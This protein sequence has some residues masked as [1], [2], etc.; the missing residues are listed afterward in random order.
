M[1]LSLLLLVFLISSLRCTSLPQNSPQADAFISTS[2]QA[3][4]AAHPILQ[5]QPFILVWNMPTANCPQRYNIHLDLGDFHIVENKKERFQG[6]VII[7]HPFILLIFY[8]KSIE[9]GLVRALQQCNR[10]RENV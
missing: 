1:E 7:P 5:N 4:A 10:K 3:V 2:L 8:F 6:Q 9:R